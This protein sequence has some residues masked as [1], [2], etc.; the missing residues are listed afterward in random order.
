VIVG[1]LEVTLRIGGSQSL[2]SRRRVVKSLKDRIRAR[3]NVSVADVGDQNVW[4]SAVLAVAVVSN[5]GGFAREVLS[6]ILR[7]VLS[8]PRVDVLDHNV[9]IV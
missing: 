9:D 2:K 1:T 6:K 5:D 7:L 3:Y 8:D 4:Q